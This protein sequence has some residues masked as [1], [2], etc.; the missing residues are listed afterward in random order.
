MSEERMTRKELHQ[1]DI[2]EVQLFKAAN[3]I[4]EQKQWFIMAGVAFVLLAL[5]IYAG[6]QYYQAEEIK[7]AN[8]FYTVQKTVRNLTETEGADTSEATKVLNDFLAEYPNAVNSVAALMTLGKL[9][10]DQ[11]QWEPAVAA[12]QQAAEHSQ[13]VPT[14]STAAKLSLA[15]VYEKLEQWEAAQQT[16][17]SIQGDEWQDIRWKAL[18]QIALAKGDKEAAKTNLQQLI[19]NA[20]DSVF[21]PEAERLLLTLN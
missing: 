6:I 2:V 13:A 4:Y 8:L 16:I 17:E 14:I 9:H 21:R 18:A 15:S 12:Y 3:F 11:Q 7:Q 1:P 5:G 20:P 19:N 10:A